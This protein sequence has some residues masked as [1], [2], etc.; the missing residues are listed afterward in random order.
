M[1]CLEHIGVLLNESSGRKRKTRV[2]R[3]ILSIEFLKVLSRLSGRKI[4]TQSKSVRVEGSRW[5]VKILKESEFPIEWEDKTDDLKQLEE[6][7]QML[8]EYGKK[9]FAPLKT[10]Y[11]PKLPLKQHQLDAL[12]ISVYRHAF[13]YFMEMGLGKTALT[14][15]NFCI[16]FLDNEIDAALILAPK[17]A[18]KQWVA[19]E[20]PKH[21]NPIIPLNM[22]LWSSGKYYLSEELK[23]VGTLNIFALNIDAV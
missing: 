10:N 3:S 11:I 21:I 6:I 5:N 14:I 12:S 1:I 13:A 16:L 17:G 20:I 8:V 18:H 22:T 19:D 23:K 2:I 4:W 9:E 15:A 7:Q